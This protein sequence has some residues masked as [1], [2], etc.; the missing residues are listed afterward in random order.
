MLRAPPSG[1]ARRCKSQD[2]AKGVSWTKRKTAGVCSICCGK[3]LAVQ[4]LWGLLKEGGSCTMRRKNR[5][6]ARVAARAGWPALVGVIAWTG[7]AAAQEPDDIIV[8]NVEELYQWVNEEKAEG[9]TLWLEKGEYILTPVDGAGHDRPHKGQLHLQQDMSIRSSLELELDDDGVPE[10]IDPDVEYATID[11]AQVSDGWIVGGAAIRVHGGTV[12]GLEVKGNADG[13]DILGI[14]GIGLYSDSGT[15]KG[16]SVTGT[17]V[18]ILAF[19]LTPDGGYVGGSVDATVVQNLIE[20]NW[21]LGI[22]GAPAIWKTPDTNIACGEDLCEDGCESV[23]C[24]YTS[25][26]TLKLLI[27][28]NRVVGSDMY[29]I[30]LLANTAGDRNTVEFETEGNVLEGNGTGIGYQMRAAFQVVRDAEGNVGTWTSTGDTFTNNS[31]RH[32]E[33]NGAQIFAA[34]DMKDCRS[35]VHLV[36]STFVC[37]NTDCEG[38]NDVYAISWDPDGPGNAENVS[39]KLEIR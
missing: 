22:G 32:V 27:Q 15:V 10:R 1:D 8:R 33:I 31:A 17:S 14:P 18:A 24:D 11:V 35:E 16:C 21:L 2:V 34:A 9:V 29:G 36:D 20:N 7:L 6:V 25:D 23:V 39:L 5:D 3:G 19:P 12:S 38:D 13:G 30:L 4:E 28:Q 37:D 26:A